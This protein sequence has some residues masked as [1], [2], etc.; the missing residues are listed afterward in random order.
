M[1]SPVS[2]P[3][4][5][6]LSGKIDGNLARWSPWAWR[7]TFFSWPWWFLTL[8]KCVNHLRELLKLQMPRHTPDQLTQN[9][10]SGT[11]TPSPML[12][13]ILPTLRWIENLCVTIPAIVK[14]ELTVLGMW[15]WRLD[16]WNRLHSLHSQLL[17]EDINHYGTHFIPQSSC[18]SH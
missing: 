13:A 3:S 8:A 14:W 16:R 6:S 11:Q 9:L 5:M 12:D 2:W 18:S 4:T 10:K 1:F 7:L 15:S 17:V